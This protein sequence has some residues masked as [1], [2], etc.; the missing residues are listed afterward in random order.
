MKKVLF[1]LLMAAGSTL[2][3][4][5]SNPS[6]TGPAPT[7]TPTSTPTNWFGY[8]ATFTPT[9][10]LTAAGFTSTFTY[11]PSSPTNTI[12]LTPVPTATLSP[13]PFAISTPLVKAT[14]PSVVYPNGLAVNAAGTTLYVAEGNGTVAGT[15]HIFNVSGTNFTAAATLTGTGSV[16]FNNPYGVAVN[17]AA[18]TFYVVDAGNSAVY[19]FNASTNAFITSWSTNGTVNLNSPEGI[20]VDSSG[21]VYV[22]DTGNNEVEKFDSAGNIITIWSTGLSAFSSPSAVALDGSNNLY[23]ADADHELVQIYNGSSWNEWSTEPNSDIFGIAVDGSGNVYVADSGNS[24]VTEYNGSGALQTQWNRSS[25]S[26]PF[27]SP[28][29][30]VFSGGDVWV[31]DF[32][33][34]PSN[35]GTLTLFGP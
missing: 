16:T 21:N 31:T 23:V 28:D 3:L 27:I 29:G 34:G 30:V 7:V 4:A 17:S 13:T 5:C 8:T 24:V 12:T 11:T 35:L 20:A 19:A 25:S 33:N 22:A 26:Y 6:P 10:N 1:I 2:P 32:E 14:G 15:I 18:T 9:P